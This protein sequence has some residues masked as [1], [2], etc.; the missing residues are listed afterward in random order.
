[1]YQAPPAPAYSGYAERASI[2]D[3]NDAVAAYLA[4]VLG[5]SEVSLEFMMS[6]SSNI[7]FTAFGNY[8]LSGEI[9]T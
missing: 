1:M 5:E 4:E 6:A 7:D 2:S 8:L 9:I 3:A